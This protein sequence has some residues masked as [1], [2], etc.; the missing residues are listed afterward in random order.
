MTP[1]WL[2]AAYVVGTFIAVLAFAVVWGVGLAVTLLRAG[3]ALLGAAAFLPLGYLLLVLAFPHLADPSNREEQLA[4]TAVNATIALVG[5][6]LVSRWYSNVEKSN[7]RKSINLSRTEMRRQDTEALRTVQALFERDPTLK[8]LVEQ[9]R[10]SQ[11]A[12]REIMETGELFTNSR[13]EANRRSSND[14]P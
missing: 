14:A 2:V 11:R 9:L 1:V 7:L 10:R 13:D 8:P 4:G 5:V 3:V 6:A 12:R